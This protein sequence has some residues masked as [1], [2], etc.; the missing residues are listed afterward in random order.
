MRVQE[1]AETFIRDSGEHLRHLRQG[2]LTLEKSGFDPD[3]VRDMLRRAHT[4]KGSAGVLGLQSLS[5]EAHDLEDLLTSLVKGEEVVSAELVDRLL[6]AAKVLE[7]RIREADESGEI[8]GNLQ[9]IFREIDG[10]RPPQPLKSEGAAA[11]EERAETVQARV[12]RL[13]QLVN[14]LGELLVSGSAFRGHRIDLG[15]FAARLGLFVHE[16]RGHEMHRRGKALLEELQCTVAG[17]DRE[18]EALILQSQALHADGMRLRMLPLSSVTGDLPLLARDLSREQ[19][20]KVDLI[21]RGE[22]VEL[23]RTVLEAV[24]P[25]LLHM[26]RNAV[27]HG[28]E[29]PGERTA[30][31]KPPAGTIEIDARYEGG[32]VTVAMK[33]DGR[34]IDGVAVRKRAL[35]LGLITPEESRGLADE[36][37][38]YL[39]L[40]PGFSTRDTVT[41]LS[42]RGV[43]MDVVKSNVDRLKGNLTLSSA[44]GRGTQIVLQLPLTL[45]VVPGLL[46]DCEGET[47]A[48]PLHY[49]SEVVRLKETDLLTE[50]GR[51]VLRWQGK[52]IPLVALKDT[53]GIAPL[54][55]ESLPEKLTALILQFGGQAMACVV[56][57][58]LEARELLI[59][60]TGAQLKRIRFFAGA[61]PLPDGSPALILSVPDLFYARFESRGTH[62][63]QIFSESRERAAR[64][65][66]LVVDDSI[67]TRTMEKNILEA[68]GYEVEVAIS[69]PEALA[70]VD[71]SDFD[72]VVTDIEMPEM[73]GFELTRELRRRTRTAEIPVA[74]VSSRASDEDRRKGIEVGAQ[75]YIVKGS[76]DRGKLLATVEAL[77]G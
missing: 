25:M 65:R 37:A 66:I 68:H 64:G 39:I 56:S 7:T 12:D 74:I 59:K 26:V 14:R 51:E 23:D 30:A 3:I 57:R 76:F 72:L 31:D 41:D 9:G 69:G 13:D 2:A 54:R 45:A 67:T 29:S 18:S 55:H 42:G 27:D 75:A 73:D 5:G 19:G 47:Y 16:L 70:K 49:V 40:R 60:G 52:I 17:L 61:T 8:L 20:K 50:G 44:P 10:S 1:F 62:L 33:D 35:R 63:R 71:R 43:G 32:L 46:I 53:L 24:R 58:S 4:L 28:I 48:V 22:E 77:I 21:I 36:E 15:D 38:L 34:G 6:G 11:G